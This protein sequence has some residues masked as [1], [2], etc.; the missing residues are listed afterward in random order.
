MVAP[1]VEQLAA[2]NKR[3]KSRRENGRQLTVQFFEVV[4]VEDVGFVSC[5]VQERVRIGA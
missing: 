3:R 1:P 5:D 2:Y 4:H